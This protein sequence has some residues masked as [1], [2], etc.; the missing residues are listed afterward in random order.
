MFK[1][2]VYWNKMNS[3]ELKIKLADEN[4]P[5]DSYTIFSSP[6]D[7]SLCIEYLAPYWSVFYS[8]RGLQTGKRSFSSESEACDYFYKELRS[9]FSGK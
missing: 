9:W 4:F 6:K 5:V 8:E 2:L 1:N 7:E 3:A